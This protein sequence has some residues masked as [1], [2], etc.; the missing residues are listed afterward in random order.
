MKYELSHDT[1]ARQ[2]FEKASTEARTRRK[3]ERFISERYAAF[4]VRGAQLTQD[5]IDFVWPHLDQVNSPAEEIAF[6]HQG[7]RKLQYKRRIRLLLLTLTSVAFAILAL[8]ANSQRDAAEIREL[9]SKSMRIG[10][11]ARYA[12]YEGKPRV[13]FRL[14]EQALIWNN[15]EDATAIA[16]EV[17]LEIQENPLV[18]SIHHQDTITAMQF[19]DDG[20]YFLSASMD[21][22]V[23]LSDLDGKTLNRLQHDSGIRW[24]RLLP[25]GNLV[26]SLSTRGNLMLWNVTGNSI[27]NLAK[28]I[29]FSS[30]ELSADNTYLGAITNNQV[31]VWDLRQPGKEQPLVVSLEAPVSSLGFLQIENKWDLITADNNG[32]IKRWNSAGE[33]VFNYQ[34]L[35]DKAVNGISVSPNNDKI[36]FRTPAGDFLLAS[37]GD[38]LKTRTAIMFRSYQPVHA[39]FATNG[40]VPERIVSISRNKEFVYVWNTG[41]TQ[42]DIDM[43]WSPRG[44]A[45][46]AA[47]SNNGRFFLGAS[48][49][50][51]NMVQLL[52]DNL[53]EQNHELFRFNNC[54]LWGVYAPNNVHFLSTAGGNQA[55]LW[56][57]DCDYLADKKALNE[58]QVIQYYQTRLHP[59]SEEEQAYYRLNN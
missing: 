19:S 24:A 55:L 29:E 2:V 57:F 48:D 44:Q 26:L 39:T 7:K 41:S 11:A 43:Q 58:A 22:E 4:E 6:L 50:N 42:S 59:L 52:A 49:D 47:M 17:M 23:R 37:N 13:A 5:D 18:R 8:W 31:Y 32:N 51:E 16:R 12:L 10:L 21:G 20:T 3:V 34:N 56:K 28:D 1:I 46:F 9:Q 38:T 54:T 14:A 45:Q 33:A 27:Q 25:P 53:K 36:I 35:L 40:K 30:A 15:D